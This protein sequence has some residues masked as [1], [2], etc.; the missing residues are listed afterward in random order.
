[1]ILSFLARVTGKAELRST[2]LGKAEEIGLRMR[3]IRNPILG[4]LI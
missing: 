3:E 2:Q 4:K 1:M